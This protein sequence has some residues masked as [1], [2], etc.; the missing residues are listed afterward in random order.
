MEMIGQESNYGK[1][2]V[3][4][5]APGSYIL[6]TTPNNTYSYMTGTSMAAPMVTGVAAL[7]YSQYKD[8]T[9]SEIRDILLASVRPLES[10]EGLVA[11]GG[12]LDAYAALT[13]DRGQIKEKEQISEKQEETKEVS[14]GSVPEL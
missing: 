7:L 10:L 11:T 3:D 9:P 8:I 12:M 5:A 13:Y 1:V 2:S 4:L 6:S 14:S